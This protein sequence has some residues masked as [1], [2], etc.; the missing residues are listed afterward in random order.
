MR[1]TFKRLAGVTATC[2]LCAGAPTVVGLA[3]AD[4]APLTP[5]PSGTSFVAATPTGGVSITMSRDRRQIKS[6][7]FAY[8]SSCNDGDTTYDYDRY[9]AIPVGANRKFSYQFKSG[10]QPVA[11]TPGATYSYTMSFTGLVNKAGTRIIGTA[12]STFAVMNPAGASFACDT[13][14]VAFKAT[15]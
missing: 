14:T 2:V 13:G 9:E 8:K 7:M 3:S 12:R 6:A 10:P 15:D 11:S 5:S 1:T 4:A